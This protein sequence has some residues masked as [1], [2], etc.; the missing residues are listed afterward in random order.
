MKNFIGNGEERGGRR[1][2]QKRCQFQGGI[3]LDTTP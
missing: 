3:T 2:A 1:A